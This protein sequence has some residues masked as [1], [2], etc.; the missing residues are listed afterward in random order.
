MQR[1]RGALRDMFEHVLHF[2]GR[3]ARTLLL[4]ALALGAVF[5]LSLWPH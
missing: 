2:D 5:V 3:L 1:F 4:L